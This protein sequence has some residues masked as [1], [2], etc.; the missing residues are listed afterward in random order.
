MPPA[1]FF[2]NLGLFVRNDFFNPIVCA[3]IR[4]QMRA[5]ESEKALIYKS[6]SDDGVLD[7]GV[8][9]SF[10][11]QV[12]K[13]TKSMVRDRFTALKPDLE[14]HFRTS[15]GECE[16][17]SFLSYGEGA[18]FKQHLDA[19]QHPDIAAR[20]VSLVV[21]LNACSKEPAADCFGGGA[22]N[23]FGLM[24]GPQWED[25]A[26]AI[27]AELGML[28]GFSSD[29]VHEVQPVTFGQRFTTVSWFRAAS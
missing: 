26:F 13:S 16:S 3:E 8:R 19:T 20:R 12:E 1:S 18:Y 10:R 23:F 15:L 24:K 5:G 27:D 2:R 25:C 28:V 22:L 9:K 7:E 14:E 29:I 4:A 11:V 21:F 6:A 17:P